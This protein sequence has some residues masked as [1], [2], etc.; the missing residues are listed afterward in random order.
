VML[1]GDLGDAGIVSNAHFV[2]KDRFTLFG[3]KR[4]Y[5]PMQAAHN[6][7]ERSPRLTKIQQ[8]CEDATY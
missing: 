3:E 6:T 4:V 8:S 2:S 1:C 5:P 7:L